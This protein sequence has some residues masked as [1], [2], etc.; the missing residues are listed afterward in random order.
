SLN[1]KPV[2]RFDGSVDYMAVADNDVWAFSDFNM[3]L[4][5]KMASISV[6]R[7]LIAQDE[8]SGSTRKWIWGY[9]TSVKKQNWHINNPGSGSVSLNGTSWT[10]NTSLY[11]VIEL[12][13]SGSNY[14][15]YQNGNDNGTANSSLAIPN[16]AALLTIGWAEGSS[17]LQGDIAELAIYNAALNAAD[18]NQTGW[19]LGDKYGLPVTYIPEPSTA[20]LLALGALALLRRRRDSGNA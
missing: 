18:R 19:Y 11:Y 16:A 20:V 17:F 12:R 4:V 8:G 15:F 10:P 3:F 7:D 6:G 1:G 9:N 5:V 13:K 14:Y 2:V